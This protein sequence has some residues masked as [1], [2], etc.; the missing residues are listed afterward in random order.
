[1]LLI[2][3]LKDD[4]RNSC[5]SDS[6]QC[7]DQPPAV[8]TNT[9]C[10]SEDNPASDYG[11]FS[12]AVSQYD[13]VNGYSCEGGQ[14][15]MGEYFEALPNGHLSPSD[16]S[17]LGQ[18]SSEHS[19][20]PS[21]SPSQGSNTCFVPVH[22]NCALPPPAFTPVS[23]EQMGSNYSTNHQCYTVVGCNG[24]DGSGRHFIPGVAM[25]PPMQHGFPVPNTAMHLQQPPGMFTGN[26]QNAPSPCN[27]SPSSSQ[28]CGADSHEDLNAFQ[29]QCDG[30]STPTQQPPPEEGLQY[31]YV[32]VD[33]G[34]SP[35][36][37]ETQVIHGK[38]SCFQ[39][40]HSSYS[41]FP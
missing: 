11:S 37:G 29:G 5:G 31:V 9:T 25:G 6:A 28:S 13:S 30:D 38:F 32:H 34:Q 35:M 8:D 41:D 10:E 12:L 19:S 39:T 16:D 20:Q 23:G 18:S 40:S 22:I 33:P 26:R 7:G 4:D 24:S 15:V 3:N 27:Y 14:V 1:M 17:A 2:F 36:E 21:Q